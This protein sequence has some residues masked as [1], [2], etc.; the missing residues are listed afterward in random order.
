MLNYDPNITCNH[1][2]TQFVRIKVQQW[3]YCK[4]YETTI[5]GN[6]S[7]FDAIRFAIEKIV[8]TLIDQAGNDPIIIE[9]TDKTGEIL[10]TGLIEKAAVIGLIDFDEDDII[11]AFKEMIVSA[12]IFDLQK[13]D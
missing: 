10:E 6:T 9:M 2:C 4:T 13:K 12:E 5:T 3:E 7:G 11:E 8:E 1:E